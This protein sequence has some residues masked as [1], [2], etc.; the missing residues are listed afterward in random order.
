[1][2]TSTAN[3]ERHP[4]EVL[5]ERAAP[6]TSWDLVKACYS[7]MAVERH[8]RS[9]AGLLRAIDRVLCWETSLAMVR[10]DGAWHWTIR[11]ALRNRSAEQGLQPLFTRL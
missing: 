4:L 3:W 7:R 2:R 9:A 10:I 6:M 5:A 8:R 11:G 1:M